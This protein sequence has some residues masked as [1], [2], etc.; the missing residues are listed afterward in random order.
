MEVTSEVTSGA[1]RP[2]EWLSTQKIAVDGEDGPSGFK[3]GAE[4]GVS[5]DGSAGI[6]SEGGKDWKGKDW[7]SQTYAQLLPFTILLSKFFLATLLSKF[8]TL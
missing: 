7:K 6:W 1:K 5:D 8:I 4:P 3:P 2:K